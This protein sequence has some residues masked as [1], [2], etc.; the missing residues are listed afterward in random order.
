MRLTSPNDI[1][2]LMERHGVHFSKALGQ[3]FLI[4]PSVPRRIAEAGCEGSP[5]GLAVLEI[6][7]GIG[8]LT[9]ELAERA[10]HVAAVELDRMLLPVLA[11]TLADRPNAE[12]VPGD[13]LK[14]DLAA[15]MREKFPG[16]RC[17]VCANLPYNV[18]T[19]L[20]AKFIDAGIFERITVMIQREVA[21]RLTAAPGTA[22]Y[23]AFTVYLTWHCEAERLFDVLLIAPCTG[24]TLAR[25]ATGLTDTAV[26]MAAKSH[27]RN[28]RP[29]VLGISTNDGLAVSLRNLG[30]L[31]CRKNL[32]LVPFRQDN[33]LTKPN[34]LVADMNQIP[35]AVAAAAQ[36][37][38]LQP[39]LLGARIPL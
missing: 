13:A 5:E 31:N 4:E 19:P 38:Q 28:G 3:N 12:V 16:A 30:D 21:L 9:V 1:R 14:L 23:G 32:Y 20:L 26:T 22:D 8:C 18:T 15:L 10:E 35:A 17:R 39:V 25:L 33:P 34:S 24:A 7:P 36:G 11:E 2:A 37:K 27:L 6:G 29:V